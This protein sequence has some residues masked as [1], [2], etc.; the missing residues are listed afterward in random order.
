MRLL[1]AA[2]VLASCARREEARDSPAAHRDLGVQLLARARAAADSGRDPGLLSLRGLSEL[3]K[4][5]ILDKSDALVVEEMARAYV[6][7]ADH[8]LRSGGDPR[9]ELE[10]ARYRLAQASHMAPAS[11]ARLALASLERALEVEWILWRSSEENP[12]GPLAQGIDLARRAL[13]A[14][15]RA[16]DA[17]VALARMHL[18]I[19]R[20]GKSAAELEAAARELDAA[21]AIAPDLVELSRLRA[22]VAALAW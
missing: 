17:H 1:L 3:D 16:A 5:R 11:A 10:Q 7:L 15:P 22:Q 8:Q 2:L 12:A 19:S 14:D 6:F 21:A 4:A 20:A 18:A 13:E 9:P